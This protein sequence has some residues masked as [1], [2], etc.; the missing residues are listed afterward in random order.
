MSENAKLHDLDTRF[1]F[2]AK[3]RTFYCDE[4]RIAFPWTGHRPTHWG[5]CRKKNWSRLGGPTLE[6]GYNNRYIDVTWH[7]VGC[8][9]KEHG[10]E[11]DNHYEASAISMGFF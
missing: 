2:K 8:V 6:Y 10:L 9:M 4:C 5:N 11:G 7:C 3:A 1:A